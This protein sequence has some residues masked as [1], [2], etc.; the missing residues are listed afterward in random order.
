VLVHRSARLAD[1]PGESSE[2]DPLVK[3]LLSDA[4]TMTAVRRKIPGLLGEAGVRA[5]VAD[6]IM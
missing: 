6:A 3:V 4:A 1:Q 5:P 2:R